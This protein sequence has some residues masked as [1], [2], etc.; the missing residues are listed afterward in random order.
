MRDPHG[1]SL[2]RLGVATCGSVTMLTLPNWPDRSLFLSG[3][4]VAI[5]VAGEQDG[6]WMM[7]RSL[8]PMN[9][10]PLQIQILL[11]LMDRTTI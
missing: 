2:D 9:T 5:M 4:T 8:M 7:F 10:Q 1:Q 6:S 3:F 11:S